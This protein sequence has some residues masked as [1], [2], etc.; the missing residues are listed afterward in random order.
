MFLFFTGLDIQGLQKSTYDYFGPDSEYENK[1]NM[2][3]KD[4][5]GMNV[6]LHV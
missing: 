5:P 1:D 2:E 4:K 6:Y 3:Y